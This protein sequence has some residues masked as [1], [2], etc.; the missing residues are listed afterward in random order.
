[1]FLDPLG[2]IH[3]PLRSE[4]VGFLSLQP[5]GAPWGLRCPLGAVVASDGSTMPYCI[6]LDAGAEPWHNAGCVIR[7]EMNRMSADVRAVMSC[8]LGT[9]DKV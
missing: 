5:D 7:S 1:M 3:R 4:V 8:F 2:D 9:A 6:Q